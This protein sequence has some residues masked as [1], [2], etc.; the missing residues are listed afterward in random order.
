MYL[1]AAKKKCAKSSGRL[2]VEGILAGALIALGGYGSQLIAAAGLPKV[3]SAAVF[4]VGLIMVVLTGS[5]LFTGNCLLAGPAWTHEIAWKDLGRVWILSYLGNLAGALLTAGSVFVTGMSDALVQTAQSAAAAKT[6]MGIPEMLVRAFLCNLLVCIAVW[7]A[8]Q[9][10]ETS[11]KILA[12]FVPVFTFV[13]LGFEH[14]IANMYFLPVGG[15][16]VAPSV[17]QIAVVTLGNI[18][19]GSVI[20]ILLETRKK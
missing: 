6:A 13:L 5:E 2:F 19:G 12:A 3:V 1:A 17:F 8:I 11:G 16:P 18:L 20:G 15:A 10:Q 9:A 7:T 14:S 4:P